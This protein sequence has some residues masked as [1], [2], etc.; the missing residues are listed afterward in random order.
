MKPPAQCA[1]WDAYRAVNTGLLPALRGN[2][3]DSAVVRSQLGA[4]AVRI[5]RYSP[6]WGVHGAM[7]VDALHSAMRLYRLGDGDEL[8][9]LIHD[10]GDRLYLLSASPNRQHHNSEDPASP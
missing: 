10:V 2:G 5:V 9:G 7:L 4:V 1:A 6:L 3:I 8:V